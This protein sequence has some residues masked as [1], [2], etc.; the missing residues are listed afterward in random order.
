MKM[1]LG[2]T[3]LVLACAACC[4]PLLV[5]LLGSAGLALGVAAVSLDAVLCFAVP[6]SGLMGW[7]IW[8]AS[9]QRR[10]TSC[11]C[12]DSCNTASGCE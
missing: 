3:A 9:R 5:V 1:R 6:A 10:R 11:G 4:V 8:Y 2:F 12:A 7:G